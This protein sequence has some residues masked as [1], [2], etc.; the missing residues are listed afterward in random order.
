MKS[1]SKVQKQADE[2]KPDT[3]NIRNSSY[4][5]KT[6][7]KLMYSDTSVVAWSRGQMF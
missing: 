5:Y 2:N 1:R 4:L 7:E 6:I 3:K